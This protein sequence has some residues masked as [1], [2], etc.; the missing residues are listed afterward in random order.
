MYPQ[1]VWLERPS[2][3]HLSARCL[4]FGNSTCLSLEVWCTQQFPSVWFFPS[5]E[6]LSCS[7]EISFGTLCLRKYT[8]H[9]IFPRWLTDNVYQKITGIFLVRAEQLQ[10][11]AVP[12]FQPQP[13]VLYTCLELPPTTTVLNGSVIH[14]IYVGHMM[15]LRIS[16]AQII[17]QITPRASI[18]VAKVSQL[19]EKKSHK[20]TK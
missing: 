19:S 2:A 16:A 11:L 15:I 5:H 9:H 14:K 18:L 13:P 17:W 1:P 6:V 4:L 7:R 3:I 12:S 8:N 10:K 20:K